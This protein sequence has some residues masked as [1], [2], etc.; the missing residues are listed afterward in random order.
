MDQPM[1]KHIRIVSTIL[2]VLGVLYL[3]AAGFSGFFGLL[4]LNN[5]AESTEVAWLPAFLTGGFILLPL[6][7]LGVFHIVTAKAFRQGK[8]WS[9][10][11][12]W[13][14]SIL[15]LGN[16]PIGTVFGVY[17]IWVLIKTGE[18]TE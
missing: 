16:V 13:I 18:S 17:A 2:I 15:N 5:Q 4:A 8:N 7:A 9:R 10:I 14:L 12:L 3:I 1:S 6:L 11:A